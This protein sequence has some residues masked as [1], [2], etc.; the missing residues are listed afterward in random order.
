MSPS[1]T[2]GVGS[3]SIEQNHVD[4]RPIV[5]M[6]FWEVGKDLLRRNDRVMESIDSEDMATGSFDS[7]VHVLHISIDFD[8]TMYSKK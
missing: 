6:V 4:Y 8:K 3:T 7:I 5:D 1:H 2:N